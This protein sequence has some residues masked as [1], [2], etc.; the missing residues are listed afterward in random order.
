VSHTYKPLL[1]KYL[2]STRSYSYKSITLQI[3]PQVF[4][5]RFFYSTKLLL[6]YLNSLQIKQRSF[7]ELGA[8]SGLIALW[9]AQ[10]GAYVTASDINPTAVEYLH[11]NKLTNKANIRI[12]QSD[13]FDEIP[14]KKFDFIAINPPYYKKNPQSF[15]D[16]SWYCGENGEYF[17]K[18]FSQLGKYI[19][20]NSKVIMCL[21]EECD[22]MMIQTDAMRV[23]FDLKLVYQKQNL[24][25]RNYIFQIQFL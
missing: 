15:Y 17:K 13:L 23:G 21:S 1:V 3:P 12:I 19:D 11:V 16:H 20:S 22:V 2:S 6:R 25:E 8:G 10:K 4:H 24:V 9:A 14:E 18:L 7:L 5:P